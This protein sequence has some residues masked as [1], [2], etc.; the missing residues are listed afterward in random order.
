MKKKIRIGV[1]EKFLKW[2]MEN[3][4]LNGQVL[5]DWWYSGS[6][7]FEAWWFANRKPFVVFTGLISF[8]F[9]LKCLWEWV[10]RNKEKLIDIFMRVLFWTLYILLLPI[11]IAVELNIRIYNWKRRRRWKT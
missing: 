10:K 6:D 1:S 7:K 4:I 3:S 8:L 11:L 5:L 2:S 9:L